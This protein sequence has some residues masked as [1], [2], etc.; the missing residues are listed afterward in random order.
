M[1]KLVLISFM[2]SS[3][4][5]SAQWTQ[6]SNFGGSIRYA[7]MDFTIGSDAYIVGGLIEKPL[8]FDAF[9]H[10]WK[11]DQQNDS[12]AQL[13]NYPGGKIY[14]GVAFVIN[15]VAYV[16]LGSDDLGNRNTELWAFDPATGQW[17]QKTNFPG[18]GRTFAVSFEAGGKGYV[19]CGD[20]YVGINRVYL[21]DFWEYDAV[22][23]SWSQKASF[24][25]ARVG[26]SAMSILG[27]GYAGLG[28]DGISFYDD[29][30]HYDIAMDLWTPL[31]SFPGANRS[32]CHTTSSSSQGYLVGGEDVSQNYTNQMW[33]FDP[34]TTQWTPMFNFS[35]QARVSGN[36]FLLGNSFYFGLG[37]IGVSSTQGANDIW[38]Y[39]QTF[40]GIESL[41]SEALEVYPNP[42]RGN[43]KVSFPEATAEIKVELYSSLGHK[44]RDLTFDQSEEVCLTLD[45]LA[46]GLYILR[47]LDGEF[48][49]TKEVIKI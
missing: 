31:G 46:K 35:G 18:S 23:D 12:W 44:V 14:G 9:N 5:L 17:T 29:F 39:E 47:V 24:P 2:L 32:F 15:S 26:M 42:T 28:D 16:G 41:D 6:L 25:T 48:I 3:S 1:K 33:N 37:L 21:N 43:V 34:V 20:T 40:V 30:Y 10:L 49:L 38:E 13:A 27:E 36:F 11:Y 8:G 22:G 7:A 4:L 19:G 45:G